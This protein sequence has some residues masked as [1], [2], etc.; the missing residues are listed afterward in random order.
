MNF[1]I[2][3]KSY[4]GAPYFTVQ[5]H[6]R[7]FDPKIHN[8][9][10]AYLK[11]VEKHLRILFSISPDFE[12]DLCELSRKADLLDKMGEVIVKDNPGTGTEIHFKSKLDGDQPRILDLSYSFP[13]TH[14]DGL[15]YDYILIDPNA[16][17]G[18]PTGFV[19]VFSKYNSMKINTILIDEVGENFLRDSF[20]LNNVLY[21]YVEKDFVLLLRESNYKSA[22]L[23][24]LI[25]I[26]PL[27]RPVVDTTFRSNTMI[28]AD[29]TYKA[30]K[31][32]EMQG[33]EMEALLYNEKVRIIIANYPTHSKE[34][35]EMFSDKIAA[36]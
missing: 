25:E 18:I 22:V 15:K 20:L 13:Q 8:N 35:I 36:L 12:F 2:N 1:K 7:I 21:D 33:F 10:D 23:Y 16:S 3:Y 32:I 29:C 9:K 11:Q 31:Q 26:S 24:H 28:L 17:L 30:F 19:I 4:P 34:L 6:Q 5:E 14:Y 27:L